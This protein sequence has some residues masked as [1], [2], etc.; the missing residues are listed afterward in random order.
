M[1]FSPG[2]FNGV[3]TGLTRYT[4]GPRSRG[5]NRVL[6]SRTHGP[7][8]A[9]L[10]LLVHVLAVVLAFGVVFTYPLLDA[11]IRRALG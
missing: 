7:K 2:L 10:S 6:F 4:G 11:Y 9:V 8:V 3:D 1:N 5:V